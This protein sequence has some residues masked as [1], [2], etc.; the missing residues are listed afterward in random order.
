VIILTLTNL[1]YIYAGGKAVVNF[2]KVCTKSYNL[3]MMTFM[4]C[5]ISKQT[6]PTR[7]MKQPDRCVTQDAATSPVGGRIITQ[8]VSS[9]V[10]RSSSANNRHSLN[11]PL[12]KA[13]IRKVILRLN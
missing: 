6:Q 1:F 12:L 10:S 8:A 5:G 3:Q 4:G 13:K 9:G 7:G 11:C 2:V